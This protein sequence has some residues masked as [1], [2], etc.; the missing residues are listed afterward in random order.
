MP[1]RNESIVRQAARNVFQAN[2]RAD[3]VA[4]RASEI[5]ICSLAAKQFTPGNPMEIR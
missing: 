3:L 2:F 1:L 4:A 5:K